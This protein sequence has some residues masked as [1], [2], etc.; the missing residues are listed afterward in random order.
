[1]YLEDLAAAL[2]PD[3]VFFLSQD[4]KVSAQGKIRHLF[5]KTIQVSAHLVV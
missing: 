1:M 5:R 3:Q 4:D 2:G